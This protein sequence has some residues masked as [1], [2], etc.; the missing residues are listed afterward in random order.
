M[1][2]SAK[3]EITLLLEAIGAGKKGATDKL[4]PLVYEE[5]RRLAHSQMAG[6]SK[7]HTLQATALV[8]EAYMRLVGGAQ[9]V[10][11]EN[12]RHFFSAA[13]RAMR[14]ILVERARRKA[15][16]KSGGDH[17]RVPL[18]SWVATEEPHPLDLLALDEAL[19]E[20]ERSEPRVNEIVMLRYFAGLSID[21]TAEA[22]DIA[23]RTVDRDWAFGK[24][25]LY[26]RITGENPPRDP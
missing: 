3:K 1:D 26:N 23:P 4:L 5:L 16:P 10:S 24:A 19:S 17:R 8:H 21:Q 6:E 9:E 15:G 11:W 18:E 13:V 14:R 2:D 25:W 7:G 20:L 22:L 12:R